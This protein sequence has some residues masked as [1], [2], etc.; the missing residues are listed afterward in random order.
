M[1]EDKTLERIHNLEVMESSILDISALVAS[2]HQ[3]LLKNGVSPE[4]ADKLTIQFSMEYWR[5]IFALS[6]GDNG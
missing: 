5:H 6:R 1:K 3:G 4:L 2:Y